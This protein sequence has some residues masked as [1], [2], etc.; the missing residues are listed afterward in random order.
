[1]LKKRLTSRTLLYI[2][3]YLLANIISWDRLLNYNLEDNVYGWLQWK[4]WCQREWDLPSRLYTHS[5]THTMLLN[6]SSH[7]RHYYFFFRLCFLDAPLVVWL[8]LYIVMN[9]EGFFHTLPKWSVSV[10]QGYFLMRMWLTA[11]FY[12]MN[13]FPLLPQDFRSFNFWII[14]PLIYRIDVSREHT[15]RNLFSGVV[16]LQVPQHFQ[17]TNLLY[18]ES[19]I[20]YS[21]SCFVVILTIVSVFG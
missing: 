2:R 15:I 20:Y 3:Q 11:L 1:M 5:C 16:G 21:I 13:V 18:Y 6:L 14:P 19:K 7:N 9:F 8:L 17:A 10:M 4:I 12:C